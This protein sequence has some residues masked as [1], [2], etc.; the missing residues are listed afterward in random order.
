MNNIKIFRQE[1]GMTVRELAQKANIAVGYI[2]TLEND[3][4]GHTNPSKETMIKVAKA[5][6]KTVPDVFFPAV[7][8]NKGE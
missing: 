3:D 8:K 6:G 2:S 5:L 1:Q 4:D 7:K